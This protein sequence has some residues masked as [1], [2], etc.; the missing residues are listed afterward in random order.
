MTSKSLQELPRRPWRRCSSC[1]GVCHW[2]DEAWVCDTC[3]DEWYPEHDPRQY[4]PPADRC[5]HVWAFDVVGG[6][7]FCIDCKLTL[8]RGDEPHDR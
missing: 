2:H 8:E 5:K 3:G 6:S 7:Y 4:G 1:R